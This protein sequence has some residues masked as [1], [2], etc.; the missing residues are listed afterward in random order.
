M[1]RLARPL[2]CVVAALAFAAVAG[3]IVAGAIA[4]SRGEDI[5]VGLADA[6]AILVGVGTPACVGLVLVLRGAGVRVAWILLGGALS[7]A[8]VMAGFATRQPRARRRSRTRPRAPGRSS[9]RTEWTRALPV[10]ARARLRL[11]RRPAAVAPLA[12][13]GRGRRRVRRRHAGAA[14]AAA[15]ARGPERSRRQPDRR[16]A[17]PRGPA[18]ARVLGLLVRAAGLAVRRRARAARALQ[19]GR[20][21]AAPAGAVAG[22]RR[23]DP[24]A[25]AGRDVADQ[26]VR[27]GRHRPTSRC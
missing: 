20:A 17:R 22:L 1:N 11:S 18:D 26:P 24:A 15:D 10:A 19:G 12:A 25:V 14:A 21:G 3:A 7:V 8:V 23:A 9:S 16:R 13:D 5:P 27:L 4:K 6:V 2:A